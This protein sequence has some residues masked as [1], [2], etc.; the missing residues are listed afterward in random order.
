MLLGLGYRKE[1]ASW[2]DTR[3]PSIECLEITA[4]HFFDRRDRELSD[5]SENF[6]LSVHGLG[7]SL[8]TPGPLDQARLQ[9]FA[10][11]VQNA[12]PRWISEH[13]AF[14]R[15]TEVDLGH[16]NSIPF[17]RE[18]FDVLVEHARQVADYCHQPLLLE[19]IT[20]HIPL[21]GEMREP[22]FLNALCNRAECGLLLDVTNLFINSRNHRFDPMEWL[23][24]VE[25]RFIKQLH[26]VGYARQGERFTDS[27]GEP[28]Q[29]ELIELASFAASYAPIEALILERDANFPGQEELTSEIKKL[30]RI[31]NN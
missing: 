27:H 23:R 1:L 13:I 12:K 15:T 20:S 4:E 14:T 9:R 10:R 5:L 28:I 22:E 29:E 2:I 19:N 31:R 24:E 7:L 8:G 16:L 6:T 21:G 30:E 3:P 25:P 11:V 26:I 17:T 18:M